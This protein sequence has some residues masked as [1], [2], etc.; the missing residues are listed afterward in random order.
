MYRLEKE[1]ILLMEKIKYLQE[2]DG[3]VGVKK[4]KNN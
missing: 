3:L 4:P 2:R 1:D